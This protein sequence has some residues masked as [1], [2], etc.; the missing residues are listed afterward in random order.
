MSNAYE[1][2]LKTATFIANAELEDEQYYAVKMNSSEKVILASTGDKMLG[3]LQDAPDAAN[4]TCLVA[5]GGITK[6]IGGDAIDAGDK[7]EVTS[8]GKFV[9]RSTGVVVGWA[10]TPCGAD[11]EQFSLLID[12]TAS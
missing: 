9:T 4:R 2:G 8:A 6:A 3:V 10:V 7:V 11:D 12:Q 1:L 5:F